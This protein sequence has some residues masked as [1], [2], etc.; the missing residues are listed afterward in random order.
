ML[1]GHI[2]V[3][4]AAKPLAPKVRLGYLIFAATAI[5][6]LCGLF[7]LTGIEGVDA[8]GASYIPWSHGLFMAG[9]WSVLGF[10]L[11]F[12]LSRQWRT[13]LI[14]GALVFSHWVLDFISHPMGMGQE[15]P[16]DLPLLFGGSRKVGLGLYNSLPAALVTE[17]G[18]FSAGIL[19]Y[20]LYTRTRDK[21]GRWAFGVLI[22][23]IFLLAVPAA[24]PKLELVPT[25]ALV[26]LLPLGNWV[27]IHRTLVPFERSGKKSGADGVNVVS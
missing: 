7:L 17:F 3:G 4:F 25:L 19:L 8:A 5:D 13:G 16:P 10:T 14:I 6:F 11:A 20:L 9:V 18:I 27:D 24:F 26:L 12:A 15:L 2:A 22:L 1:Y 23:F 21:V